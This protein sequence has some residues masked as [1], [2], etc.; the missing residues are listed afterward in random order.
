MFNNPFCI[1]QD[2]FISKSNNMVSHLF[3]HLF[4]LNVIFFLKRFRVI[5]SVNL[6]YQSILPGNKIHNIVTYNMLAKKF[7]T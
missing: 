1:I 6:N 5:R 2:F 3:K 4:P 7:H